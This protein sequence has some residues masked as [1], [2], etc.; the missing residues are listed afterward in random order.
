MNGTGDHQ[1]DKRMP[2]KKK[3]NTKEDYN[4]KPSDFNTSRKPTWCTGC[5]NF[6]I[7]N[8]MKKAFVKLSLHPHQVLAV[9]GIGCSGNG[10]NFLRSYSFHSLHG[11][12]LP[13][14]TGAKIANHKM[15]V[16]AVTGDGDGMGI[17]GN[18]FIH[19]CR[20][21]INIT[22]IV[23]DNHVYGL[24]TGQTSP[25]SGSGF[26]SKST[27]TGALEAPVNPISLALAAGATFVARGF[28]GDIGQLAEIIRKAIKH[29]GFSFID[30]LQPCVTFNKIDSYDYYREKVYSIDAIKA[31]DRTNLAN[32]FQKSIEEEK[33]P[34]GIFYQVQK[35]TYEDGLKQIDRKPLT[36][37]TVSDIDINKLFNKYY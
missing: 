2:G 27:P 28:S 31:Y 5:G 14:A 17:G 26:K 9:Y 37:H 33:I 16:L 4:L 36:D 21:N 13:I 11:R 30:I 23:H 22:N 25:T 3:E 34:T 35:P 19:T 6:A 18:H 1:G 10:V 20:R 29:S 24:T 12:A 15:V 7:W 8:A 32:A